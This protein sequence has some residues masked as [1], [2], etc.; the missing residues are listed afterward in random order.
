MQKQTFNNKEY[1]LYNGEKYFSKGCKRLHRVVWEF[2]NGPIPDGFDIHHKD[3]NTHNNDI[4]N[5]ELIHR[6]EHCQHHMSLRDKN[7]LR[8][9]MKYARKYAVDWHKSEEGS[10]WHSEQARQSYE[11]RNDRIL[12]CEVCKKEY[13]T[14][15]AG[16]SKYCHNNCKAKALRMRRKSKA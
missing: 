3:H 13:K 5:L 9:R 7:E 12:V 4:L 8:E 11:K 16:V 1:Y 15:H 14:K 2:Y 6:I 10:K